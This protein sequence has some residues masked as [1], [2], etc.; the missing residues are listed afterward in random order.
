MKNLKFIQ[1]FKNHELM[2]SHPLEIY[3]GRD[4]N[5]YAAYIVSDGKDKHQHCI[6]LV[7]NAVYDWEKSKIVPSE[8]MGLM[9][10]VYFFTYRN[11]HENV[12]RRTTKIK[13]H[14]YNTFV[15]AFDK[16]LEKKIEDENN[17]D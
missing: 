14:T 10:T 1:K 6:D 8:E 3:G 17:E 13:L 15:T 11:V 5:V 9:P 7:D 16:R 2:T 4:G 12:F